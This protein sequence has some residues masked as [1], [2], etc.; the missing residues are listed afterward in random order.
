[1]FDSNANAK[2]AQR[3]CSLLAGLVQPVLRQLDDCL[4]K[5][6]V[7]TFERTL[8]AIVCFRNRSCG[9]L[10]S[11]LGGYILNPAQAP[12]GTKRLSNLLR[13]RKWSA[14][15]ITDFL[16][17]LANQQLGQLEAERTEAL[18]VW[19]ESVVEKP[20]SIAPEGLCAVRSSKAARLKRIKPGYFNPPG[21]RPIFVPGLNSVALLLLGLKGYP[22]LAG[23]AWWTTRGKFASDKRTEE[24]R[25]LQTCA[26]TWSRRV[27]HV[28]D[29]GFA[30]LPWLTAVVEYHQ[31]FVMRWPAKNTLLDEQGQIRK[32]WEIVQGKR[33]WRTY[34]LWD[35]RRHCHRTV[36][37]LAACVRHAHLPHVPLWLVVSRPGPGRTPWYLLTSEP[38]AVADD[39]WHLVLCYA[40]RWQVEMTWRYQKT[41]LGLESPRLWFWENRLKLLAIVALVYAFLLLLA[42]PAHSQLAHCLLRNWCHRTGKWSREVVAPLYRLRSALSRLWLTHPPGPNI[43]LQN[44]G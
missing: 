17:Q 6:L 28:W 39:A 11:E 5:R 36:G 14:E 44:P 27:L 38:I 2:M 16:W 43:F 31:R 35:A 20:E 40:R 3:A 7:R 1:M 34:R 21:G 42:H 4:D 10:L 13:S 22:Q 18:L 33:N 32:A 41:E 26:K 12:A 8:Q 37:V 15:L 9:L 23:M 30:G 24:Y 25:L 29:R 19:D